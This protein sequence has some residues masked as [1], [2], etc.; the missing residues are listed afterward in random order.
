MIRSA[1]SDD[2]GAAFELDLTN[3]GGRDLRVTRLD[4][5]VEHGE[6]GFPVANGSWKGALD[7]PARGHATLLLTTPFDTPPMEADSRLLQLGGE[8]FFDDRTGY[9]GLKAMDLTKT[10]FRTSIQSTRGTP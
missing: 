10:S 3:P 2:R 8:L 1:R 5:E 4:Y 6:S 7:L 9:L